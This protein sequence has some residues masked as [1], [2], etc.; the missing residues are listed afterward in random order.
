MDLMAKV[1]YARNNPY[2][3]TTQTSWHI[4]NFV[5]RAIPPNAGDKP[6]VLQQHH[7]HR[8][9][10]LSF[11]LYGTPVYWWV[12]CIRNPFLRGDPLWGFLAGT[13]IMVPSLIHI[14]NILGT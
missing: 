1:N 7:E 3:S 10:K 6:F 13:E 9:D 2:F 12:F 8:P 5:F 4:N 14:H 11:D